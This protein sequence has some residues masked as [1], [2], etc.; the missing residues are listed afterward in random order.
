[1]D[2]SKNIWKRM[3]TEDVLSES[4]FK[5][6]LSL[7]IIAGLGISS[8]CAY[9]MQS[10]APNIWM[11]LLVGLFIPI[12]GII[13]ATTSDDWRIS[14]LGYYFVVVGFGLLLGPTI[15][16]FETTVVVNALIAT[17][18][19]TILMSFLGVVIKKDLSHW[20]YY[21]F[22]A[23]CTLL[24][25]RIVQLFIPVTYPNEGWWWR[26]VDYAAA[27]LFSLYILYD[28]NRA[29]SV[30]KTRDNAVDCALA[31]YLDIVNLFISLLRILGNG[32]KD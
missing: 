12:I 14:A 7:W 6:Q 20:G 18:G 26:F 25:V 11:Y 1:M 8:F 30:S 3:D 13:I 17:F 21:L 23:L 9:F 27:V 32:T 24:L 31:I 28:W 19:I 15:G 29:M 22:I 16:Y 2:L 10:W 4:S 5:V